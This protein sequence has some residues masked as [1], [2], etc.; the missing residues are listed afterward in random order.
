MSMAHSIE[1]RVPLLDHE[2]VEFAL[3]VPPYLH[4]RAGRTKGLFKKALRGMLP[5]ETL[6]R[7]KQGFA[8][9][10]GGWFRGELSGY[11]REQLLSGTARRRGI[12]EPRAVEDVLERSMRGPNDLGLPVWT[13]L[14][15]ELWCRTFL[16]ARRRVERP[17]ASSDGAWP[18][19]VGAYQPARPR[20]M[21]S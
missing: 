18:A 12:F 8:V 20:P 13:L 16:D 19:A 4:L 9:P 3:R 14:C 10:L 15:F 7:P 2:L 17:V 6:A 11:V 1:A 21:V 5:E